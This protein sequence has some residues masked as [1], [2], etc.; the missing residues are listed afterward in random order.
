MHLLALSRRSRPSRGHLHHHARPAI[1]RSPRPAPGVKFL[2]AMLAFGAL[3]ANVCY[4]S[5]PRRAAFHASPALVVPI[6][7]NGVRAWGD[8]L[9][10]LPQR[11]H[12]LR[13]GLRPCR[14]WLDLLRRGD[15]ADHGL[16][17]ALLRPRASTI[18]GS[19]RRRSQRRRRR[20]RAAR[21]D[22]VAAR[23]RSRSPPRRRSGRPRSPPPASARAA[24]RSSL[25][26][27]CRAGSACRATS[28]RPWQPHYRRRR[29]RSASP[30]I[31]TRRGQEVDLAIAVFARQERG[32]RAGRLRPGRGRA[33]RRLGLDRRRR[34]RRRADARNGSPRTGRCAR[35]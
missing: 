10:R 7:A 2:I 12:R 23:G 8:D 13:R 28:G 4:R 32:P 30:A 6:L 27:R 17:L 33:R 31:A 1:S 16:R 3:V 19:T 21:L 20:R 29:P 35:C 15:R 34:R 5:W 11:Q 22:L 25:C 18:P 9:H 14:L 26:P 24:R